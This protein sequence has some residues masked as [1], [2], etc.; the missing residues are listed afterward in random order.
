[1]IK[2]RTERQRE[3]V[4]KWIEAD[5]KGTLIYPTGYGVGNYRKEIYSHWILKIFFV[6][7]YKDIFNKQ[8]Q[9]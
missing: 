2:S 1:M 3:G 4:R 9:K 5:G 6:F 8:N 7:L